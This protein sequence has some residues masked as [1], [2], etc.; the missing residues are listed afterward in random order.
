MKLSPKD[1]A[2]ISL[3]ASVLLFMMYL[4]YAMFNL[5]SVL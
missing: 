3:S 4:C 2:I 1:K 5:A